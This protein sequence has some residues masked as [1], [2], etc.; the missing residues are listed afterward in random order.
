[1]TPPPRNSKGTERRIPALRTLQAK[2]PFGE[3]SL[4]GELKGS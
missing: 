3:E 4:R 2:S 1:M